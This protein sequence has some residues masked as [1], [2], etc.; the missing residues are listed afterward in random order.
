MKAAITRGLGEGFV[1]EELT[2]AEPIGHEVL[3][4]VRASGLCHS[5]LHFATVDFGIPFPAVL[6]HELSGVVT[7]VG[8]EVRDFVVGQHVVGSLVQFCGYCSDCLAGATY[9]CRRGQ[10]LMRTPDQSPRLTDANRDPVLPMFGTAA[11]AEHA[12]VHENQLVAIPDEIP[13]PQASVLGCATITGAGAAINAAGIRTGE[14]AVVIGAGGIGLNIISGAALAGAK[15]IIA[16]DL[17]DE[18]LEFARRFGATHIVNGGAG[19]PIAAVHEITG[20]GADH[21]FEAIGLPVTTTQAVRMTRIGGQVLLIGLQPPGSR[22]EIAMMDD[23]I[24][25]QRAVKGVFMGSA[26][27]KRDI[28]VYAELYLQGRLNLDDLISREIS[29]DEI[30]EAYELMKTGQVARSVITRW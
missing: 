21:A 13:F 18:K 22:M 3:V 8:P 25:P 16:V 26:N 14:T 29:I 4:E 12:L 24:T 7:A 11:F 30:N 23:I 5:D 10:E 28:P 19:D 17:S 9:R 15:K 20:G 2:I 1:V 6:G 27:I